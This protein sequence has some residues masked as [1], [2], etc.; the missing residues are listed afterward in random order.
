MTRH[1]SSVGHLFPFYTA[2]CPTWVPHFG[3]RHWRGGN[4]SPSHWVRHGTLEPNTQAVWGSWLC[5]P[6]RWKD[7]QPSEHG[8]PIKA[9][10]L[11]WAQPDQ[12]QAWGWVCQYQGLHQSCGSHTELLWGWKLV[13]HRSWSVTLQ[14][15]ARLEVQSLQNAVNQSRWA[16]FVA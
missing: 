14:I 10:V 13:R 6:V 8:F 1:A 16:G 7:I 12:L 9:V 4:L 3:V 2:S 11:A 15:V 5:I